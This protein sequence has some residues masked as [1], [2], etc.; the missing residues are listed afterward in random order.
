MGKLAKVWLLIQDM[1][2]IWEDKVFSSKYLFLTTYLKIRALKLFTQFLK[3]GHHQIKFFNHLIKY[4]DYEELVYIF[5]E[6]FIYKDYYFISNNTKPCIVDLGS[7]IGLSLLFF[8]M[9][10]PESEIMAFEA[11]D[12]TFEILKY[13][14]LK[15]NILDVT[16]YN[17]AVSNSIGKITFY[18]D[19]NKPGCGRSGIMSKDLPACKEI[20]AVMLSDYINRQVDF[21]KMDI[22]GA[23]GL[24]LAELAN[25]GRLHYIKKMVFEYHTNLNSE[26]NK[27][28]EILRILEDHNFGYQISTPN[29]GFLPE[30][31]V[32]SFLIFAY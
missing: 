3:N 12:K 30:K 20:E 25:S 2:Y 15:N 10:Y 21:L 23:E 22:E 24:V 6:I 1:G 16:L 19:P 31:S 32:E 26:K 18:Y 5:R 13:N 29:R 11:D 17:K 27:L 28:S 14:I 8:K 4:L 9:I 7:N